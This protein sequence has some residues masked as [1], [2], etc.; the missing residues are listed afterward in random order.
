MTMDIE[1]ARFNMVEQ[2]IRP[3]EVLDAT[4]LNACAKMPREHFVPAAYRQL[5]FCDTAIEIGHGQAMMQ[6][7][8]EARL[9]Q[10]LEVRRADR[11]LEI[12]T[13]TGYLTALLA[14]L[15]AHVTSIELFE[16]LA[17]C[18]KTNL[19]QAGIT[20]VALHV[21]D[22]L[23]GWSTAEPYDVIVAT[24]SSP[25]RRPRIEQQLSLNGRMFIVIGV[26]PVMEALLITRLSKDSWATESLFETELA[27]LLG[28]ELKPAF[29]F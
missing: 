28:A 24:G 18:A 20:N 14:S 6:P 26:A 10:A 29:E 7:K 25:Q 19:R 11:V 15:T 17:S 8:L 2:Q 27:P 16:D 9:L 12:G 22:A 21:G 1:T 13:G 4:V 23:D 5:A 3:W